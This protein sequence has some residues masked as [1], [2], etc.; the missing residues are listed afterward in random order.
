LVSSRSPSKWALVSAQW[1]NSRIRW[2]QT[3]S[4]TA[5]LEGTT[6]QQACVDRALDLVSR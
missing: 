5:G 4:S 1:P 3:H 2:W 6:D